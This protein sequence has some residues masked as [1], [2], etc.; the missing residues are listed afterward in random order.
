MNLQS[1]QKIVQK[2]I[3]PFEDDLVDLK[4]AEFKRGDRPDGSPIGRYRSPAYSLF[5]QR[6]NPLAGGDVDLILT[7]AFINSAFFKSTEPGKYLFGFRD[8]KTP[9]LFAKYG[10]DIAGL[11]QNTFNRF[12]LDKIKPKFIL[13][14]K[15]QLGQR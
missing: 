15:Q 10:S 9:D 8:Y 6:Q 12:L 4:E 14:I 13:N 3:V 5:K 11:N 2:E 1:L 7:G